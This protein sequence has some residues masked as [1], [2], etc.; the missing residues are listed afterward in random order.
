MKCCWWLLPLCWP[1]AFLMG[2]LAS[3]IEIEARLPFGSVGAFAIVG[4]GLLAAAIWKQ[5]LR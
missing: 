4:S 1:F 3:V 2:W 5:A